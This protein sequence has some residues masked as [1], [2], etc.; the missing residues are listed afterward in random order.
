M[1]PA[2][3]RLLF[4]LIASTGLRI[5]EA[6]GLQVKHLHLAGSSPHLR[7]RRAV[8]KRRVEAPKTRHGKRSVPLPDPLVFKLREHLTGLSDQSA[9]A[10][11]FP[12][13]RG[14][15]LNADNLRTRIFKPLAEEVG[16]EWAG[17]HALR[18]TFASLQLARGV[19]L[20]QLSRAL[21]HHSAAFTLSVY[22]HLLEGEQAPPLDLSAELSSEEAELIDPRELAATECEPRI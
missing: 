9:D 14:T 12:S 22:A 15:P 8:V 7:V 4:E 21:G 17:F 10:L 6:V 2:K 19:N 1:A 16:A 3:Y 13:Q 5:S 20:L 18:H 11:L